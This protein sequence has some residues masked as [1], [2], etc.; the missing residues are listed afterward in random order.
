MSSD[1]I[2]KAKVSA[3][4]GAGAPADE[5]TSACDH[6]G[7]S[8]V[9]L[10]VVRRSLG[11]TKRSFCCNGCSFIAEQLFLA[12]A[13]SKD[14]EALV[15]LANGGPEE[16]TLVPAGGYSQVQLPI[17]GMV[18]SACA[19]LIEYTLRKQQGVARANVDFGAQIAYI[20][21]DQSLVTRGELQRVI[22]RAGYDAGR[23]PIDERRVRRIELLRV[24]IA[25]LGMMQVMML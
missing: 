11:P 6:C 2:R 20:T 12:Q 17:R 16:A 1:L 22:E 13:G 7:D 14:R 24:L 21:F 19:L 15:S 5:S 23:V 25:W 10:R 8:L 9:G 4:A 3:V 18:C